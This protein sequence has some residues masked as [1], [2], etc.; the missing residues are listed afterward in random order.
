MANKVLAFILEKMP[1]IQEFCAGEIEEIENTMTGAKGQ[2]KKAELDRQAIAYV[3][4]LIIAWDI[5]QVPN[6]IENNIL[7][8]AVINMFE[9]YLPQIT[10]IIYNIGI[11]GI[12]KIENIID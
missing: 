9:M 2:V 1:Q 10:Q 6:I 7:D 4:G 3:S 12:Q 5:P 8:P 11:T